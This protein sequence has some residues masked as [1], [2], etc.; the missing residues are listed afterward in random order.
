MFQTN[1]DKIK[2]TAGE[3]FQKIVLRIFIQYEKY[4]L[5]SFLCLK[6]SYKIIPA[7]TETF[8]D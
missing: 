7:E 3:N 1:G 4:Y 6:T 8:N 5:T 2:F